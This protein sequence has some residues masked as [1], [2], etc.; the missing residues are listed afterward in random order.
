MESSEILIGEK[1]ASDP[2][3]LVQIL[4]KYRIL[5]TLAFLLLIAQHVVYV[6]DLLG[7]LITPTITSWF[8]FLV[9]STSS[10][11][12]HIDLKARGQSL[13]EKISFLYKNNTANAVHVVVHITV[14]ILI[15]AKLKSSAF[16]LVNS[17]HIWVIAIEALIIAYWVYRR[18]KDQT[19]GRTAFRLIQLLLFIAYVPMG[20]SLITGAGSES[21]LSWL[22]GALAAIPVI[23]Q[24]L[25]QRDKESALYNGRSLFTNGFTSLLIIFNR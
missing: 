21:L 23:I 7:E 12:M 13:W 1:E 4:L 2:T 3:G 25:I 19:F 10:A 17:F 6:V 15:I 11:F 16:D 9:G 18:R 20:Y 24:A 8:L 5:E 14:I 22:F